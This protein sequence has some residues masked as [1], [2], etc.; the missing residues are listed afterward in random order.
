MSTAY[1]PWTDGASKCT[2]KTLNQ[3]VHFHVEWNQKGWVWALPIIYF[4]I[5]NSVNASTGFS[6]FQICMEHSPC[7]MPPL[8]QESLSNSTSEIAAAH[9]I[10]SWIENDIT[11]AKN[12][13]LGVKVMQ[14]FFTNKLCAHEEHYDISNCIMLATLHHH[15]EFKA[16]DQSRVAK[17][18][19]YWDGFFSVMKCFSESSSYILHLPNPP[20]MLP[21]T[22]PPCPNG[23]TKMTPP[24]PPHMSS[25]SQAL[26]W[27]KMVWKNTTLRRL[28]TNE[29]GAMAINT[30]HIDLAIL[31]S[32][33]CGCPT[34]N[35][36]TVKLWTNGWLVR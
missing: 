5:M 7:I 18:F 2:N 1:H 26:L 20:N 28:S 35:W 3:C 14:A 4:Y 23:S 6:G 24:C 33:T 16:G 30:S 10:I 32:M 9:S 13:L 21:P 27:Q 17:V 15:Q 19:P 34:V 25:D 29:R 8:M 31:K 36:K 22:M 12:T 11:K